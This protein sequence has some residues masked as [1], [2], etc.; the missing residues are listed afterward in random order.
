MSGVLGGYYEDVMRKLRGNCSR[1]I[2]LLRLLT[3]TYWHMVSDYRSETMDCVSN[4][5]GLMRV[6]PVCLPA[7]DP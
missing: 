4:G 1:G 2:Y 7:V 3:Y 5:S 6:L